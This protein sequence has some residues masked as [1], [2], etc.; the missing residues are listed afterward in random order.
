MSTRCVICKNGSTHPGKTTVTLGRY[1][2]ILVVR[3]VPAQ[4]CRN[5]GEEYV[6]ETAATSLCQT[7]EDREQECSCRGEP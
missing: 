1:G 4:V 6:D 3:G 5:C 2:T 7:A